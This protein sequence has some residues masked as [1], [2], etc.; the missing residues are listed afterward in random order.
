MPMY[1]TSTANIAVFK[2]I[3]MPNTASK[4]APMTSFVSQPISSSTTSDSSD[5]YL[6]FALL[7]NI[8]EPTVFLCVLLPLALV[9]RPPGDSSS[10]T[11]LA[12]SEPI[13]SRLPGC[14]MMGGMGGGSVKTLSHSPCPFMASTSA[15]S[16]CTMS[17]TCLFSSLSRARSRLR[18]G[19]CILATPLTSSSAV[20]SSSPSSTRAKMM[21]GSFAKRLTSQSMDESHCLTTGSSTMSPNSSLSMKPLP[22]WSA[23]SNS[24]FIF[25]VCVLMALSFWFS[26]MMSS[27]E[28][29]LNVT[30]KKTPMMTFTTAKPMTH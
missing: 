5:W 25:L 22:S 27:V 7:L 4:R 24:L 26:I 30:C 20:S 16:S 15:V 18:A 17:L 9:G 14:C 23:A 10:V 6:L 1:C 2:K 13:E 29:T 8:M 3:K 12:R 28:A 21:S 19:P 11:V